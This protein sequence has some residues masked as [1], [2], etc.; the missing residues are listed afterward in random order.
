MGNKLQRPPPAPQPQPQQRHF[1]VR[2]V[3][4]EQAMQTQP[5]QGEFQGAVHAQ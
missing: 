2:F 4:D 3:M 1:N 5:Q